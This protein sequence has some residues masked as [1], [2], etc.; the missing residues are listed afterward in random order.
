MTFRETTK[1]RRWLQ[2]TVFNL[3]QPDLVCNDDWL[4]SGQTIKPASGTGRVRATPTHRIFPFHLQPQLFLR[5]VHK[6]VFM[7]TQSSLQCA[8]LGAPVVTRRRFETDETGDLVHSPSDGG[9]TVSLAESVAAERC[10]ATLCDNLKIN[11][12][13]YGGKGATRTGRENPCGF[14]ISYERAELIMALLVI[15]LLPSCPRPGVAL[16][17]ERTSRVHRTIGQNGMQTVV[18]P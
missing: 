4:R 8:A 13:I 9:W 1:E 12:Y 16:V 14:L 5:N 10:V 6:K 3:T 2:Y 15:F 7:G 18:S 11:K 17:N